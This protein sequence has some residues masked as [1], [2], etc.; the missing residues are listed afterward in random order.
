MRKFAAIDGRGIISVEQGPIPEPQKGE[1]LIE[2][3][4]SMISPG[5]ELGGVKSRRANPNASGSKRPFGYQNA[6]DVIA[7]GEDCAEFELGMRVA[8]MGGGYAL[9]ATHAC[10]PKNLSVPIPDGV[11]YQEAAANHLAA[12]ALHT[13]RRAQLQIGENIVVMGL[14]VVGQLCCQIARLSG[15]YVMGVDKLPLRVKIAQESGADIAV[16][17][18]ENDPVAVAQEFTRGYGMDGGIICF[19]GEGTEA[20]RQIVAMIKTAPD[21]HKWGRIVIVGG[22]HISHGFAAALGN[23]DVRSA[24]RTGP[25]YHDEQYERGQDYP[26]VF[27]EW[28]TKRNLEECLRLMALGRLKVKSIITDEFPLDE[29]PAACEKLIQTPNEALG[30]ILRAK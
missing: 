18:D 16:N 4:A 10:V 26:P 27:V 24:A 17:A 13:I 5:T 20:F 25:G 23:I 11:T 9:H 30:V 21:T 3:H 1:I 22:A 28:N 19:G 15:A 7:T 6:G 14:G 8:C 12:T 2:V 29:A